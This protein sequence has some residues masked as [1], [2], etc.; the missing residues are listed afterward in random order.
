MPHVPANSNYCAW[1][2]RADL[3]FGL[4]GNALPLGTK[5][6]VMG[7]STGR[8]PGQI[9]DLTTALV[10]DISSDTWQTT[11][12][13]PRLAVGAGFTTLHNSIYL[14]GGSAGQNHGWADYAS[15][16]KGSIVTKGEN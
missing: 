10:Y 1:Q 14:I 9:K 3:P 4:V 6:Y 13:L 5:V 2:P 11:T 12:D 16:F 8:I 15:T 7:C